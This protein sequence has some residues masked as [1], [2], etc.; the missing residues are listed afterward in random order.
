MGRSLEDAIVA[1]GLALEW[2]LGFLRDMMNCSRGDYILSALHF[3]QLL[4]V[5]STVS[6]VKQTQ[7]I[8]HTQDVAEGLRSQWGQIRISMLVPKMNLVGMQASDP[9][10]N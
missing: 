7:Q 5:A 8:R 2:R 1:L 10:P 6:A 3:A 9:V 4:D